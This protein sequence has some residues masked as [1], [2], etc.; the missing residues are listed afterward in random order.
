MNFK[1]EILKTHKGQTVFFKETQNINKMKDEI[2]AK[3]KSRKASLSDISL[4]IKYFIR[5][6]IE[7]ELLQDI[8]IEDFGMSQE[9]INKIP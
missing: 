6:E 1:D 2:I 8:L 5:I 7:M 3:F 4:D 9:E